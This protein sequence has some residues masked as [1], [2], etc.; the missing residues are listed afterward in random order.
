MQ[1]VG[2]LGEAGITVRETPVFS[3]DGTRIAFSGWTETETEPGSGLFSINADIYVMNANGSG[4]TRLTTHPG[5]DTKPSF[6]HDG[7]KI[8]FARRD[9]PSAGIY[10]VKSTGGAA[11]RLT[12]TNSNQFTPAYSPDDTRIA[13][14]APAKAGTSTSS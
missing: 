5:W 6:S 13:F 12:I 1:P 4:L 7:S 14:S 11:T 8:V 2:T 10:A 9:D 3:S